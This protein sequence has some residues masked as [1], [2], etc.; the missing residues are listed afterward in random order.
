M[1]ILAEPLTV[2]G[3]IFEERVIPSDAALVT[4]T[5]VRL[6][7]RLLEENCFSRNQRGKIELCLDEAIT[8][9]VI[10]GNDRDFTKSVHIRLWKD[11]S[12]WGVAITDE[13]GGFTLDDISPNTED[14]ELWNESGRGLALLTLY[15]DAVTYF[16][17]GR[18]LLLRREFESE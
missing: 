4:P 8:N 10:H 1:Q 3:E 9:A 7:E 5:V 12:S 15:M 13:G 18:T 14:S 2:P 16:D 6:V 17:N 11:D